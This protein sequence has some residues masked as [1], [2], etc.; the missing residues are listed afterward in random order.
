[1]TAMQMHQFTFAYERH[2]KEQT[3]DSTFAAARKG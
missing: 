3:H 2:E 1:M